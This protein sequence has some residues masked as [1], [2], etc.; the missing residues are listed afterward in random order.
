MRVFEWLGPANG[1]TPVSRAASIGWGAFYAIFLLYAATNR[2]GFLVLDHANLMF[3]EA[4]HAVF[5]WAG[6]YTQV[7]GGTIGELLVPLLCTLFFV[8]RGETTAVAFCAFWGFENLLYVAAYM[9]DARRLALPLVGSDES[10]W[11]IL[12]THWG[13]LGDDRAI[14]A[15]TRGLG[16][17]GMLVTVGWFAWMAVT[18]G[19]DDRRPARP[20]RD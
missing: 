18:R 16:W 4:G 14:A 12:F 2:S 5:G 3:H 10:D 6:Y 15:V 17:M 20:W 9:A 1:W 11:T 13:V 8:R 7:L 19:E